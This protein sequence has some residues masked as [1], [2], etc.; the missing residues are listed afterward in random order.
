MHAEGSSHSAEG[1]PAAPDEDA[2]AGPGSAGSETP[3]ERSH[4]TADSPST[5]SSDAQPTGE[6][7]SAPE[8]EGPI[9]ASTEPRGREGQREIP[10]EEAKEIYANQARVGQEIAKEEQLAKR[11]A[12]ADVTFSVHC[13][14]HP[15]LCTTFLF[16]RNPVEVY[17]GEQDGIEVHFY[18]SAQEV[19]E[20]WSGEMHLAMRIANGYVGYEGPVRK[21]LRVVPILRRFVERYREMAGVESE[22]TP[23]KSG[24]E[25]P[26]DEASDVSIDPS[27]S[28]ESR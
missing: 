3:A 24:Y 8:G 22:G 14:D 28:D 17:E 21:V 25:G 4:Y 15:D 7:F 2:G 6:M 16:D 5:N 9:R 19:L 27:S 20:F 12:L 13:T 1:A 11:L 18:S 26:S 23:S 10:Y